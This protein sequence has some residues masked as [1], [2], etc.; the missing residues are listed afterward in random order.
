MIVCFY[1][2]YFLSKTSR[3]EP[4][5]KFNNNVAKFLFMEVSMVLYYSVRFSCQEGHYFTS[6]VSGSISILSPF[7]I[8]SD[9]RACATALST[10]SWITLLISLAPYSGL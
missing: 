1:D 4:N 9:K 2:R 7:L 5:N 10:L 6:N 3:L 8:L